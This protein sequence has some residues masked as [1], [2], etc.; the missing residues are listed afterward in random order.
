M[1][2][3]KYLLENNLFY[4]TLNKMLNHGYN[5][6]KVRLYNIDIEK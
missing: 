3:I 5:I 2:D 6:Q 4:K 1:K